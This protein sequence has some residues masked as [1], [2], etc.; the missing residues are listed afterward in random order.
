MEEVHVAHK[1]LEWAESNQLR[2]WWGKGQLD[3]SFFPMLDDRGTTHW[4]MSVW[5]Y[6]GL[7]V[8]FQMMQTKP[9]FSFEA[10]RLELLHRLNTISGVEI[11]P[12][13]MTRRPPVSLSTL[14]DKPVLGQFL[15]IFD[16]V[17]QEVRAS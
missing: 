6:G 12:D 4:L 3:G 15:A 2:I 10:K 1:I 9:P 13:G 8:Q 17:I 16:W 14:K 11:P 7:E 5:T